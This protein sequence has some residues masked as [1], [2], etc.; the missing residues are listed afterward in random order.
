[1]VCWGSNDAGQRT[2]PGGAFLQ[3]AAGRRHTC[4]LRPDG[5]AVCWGSN[6]YEMATPPTGA[7]AQV[8]AGVWFSCGLRPNGSI[9]C[10]GRN[11][12]LQAAPPAGTFT[13]LSAGADHACA[14]R[15]DGSVACWGLNDYGQAV[16]PAGTFTQVSAGGRHTCALRPDGA[17]VCWGYNAYGQAAPP[18]GTFTQISAGSV[19]NCGIRPSGV[20]ACWGDPN[21]GKT[22]PPTG[23]FAEVSA[24]VEHACATRA[25]GT[26]VCWGA[27]TVNTG[28]GSQFGQSLPPG[29][30]LSPAPACALRPGGIVSWWPLDGSAADG[31]GKHHGTLLGGPAALSRGFV[32]AAYLFDGV[33]DRIE[34][35][36]APAL[37]PSSQM[38]LAAWVLYTGGRAGLNRDIVGK[39]ANAAGRQYLLNLAVIDRFGATVVLPGGP[40][41]GTS[42]TVPVPNRWYHLAMTY[43]GT[44]LRFYVD[45]RLEAQ[46]P[47]TGGIATGTEPLRIGGG[48]PGTLAPDYFPGVID[49]VLLF[50]RA[51]TPAEV[52]SLY[53]GGSTGLCP[54]APPSR[55]SAGGP[56]AVNEGS[57][58]TLTAAGTDPDGGAVTLAWDF[59]G[60][61]V[62]DAT[63]AS[64]S[65]TFP[66]NGAYAVS[67]TVTDDEG[68]SAKGATTVTVRNVA[69]SAGF[70][71]SPSPVG[72]NTN[73]TLTL[74]GATDPSATDRTGGLTY[75][76]DCG[77]GVFSAYGPSTSRTCPGRS[78]AGM[79]TVRGRVRDKDL[80][81][82]D[83]AKGLEISSPSPQ[84][85]AYSIACKSKGI[86]AGYLVY[87]RT[88]TSSCGYDPL[89]HTNQNYLRYFADAKIGDTRE[90]C[91]GEA[92]PVGWVRKS[93]ENQLGRCGTVATING[94]D[95][96]V[97]VR[98]Y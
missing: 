72:V 45:G 51:I 52:G 27:G 92:T 55:V 16:P 10:W 29:D 63:G 65:R 56:Y 4:A 57:P 31:A 54:L 33:D 13:Q 81:F 30:Q 61:G 70:S 12:V 82:S 22:A 38:T 48:A 83:Y 88:Y 71:V 59:T 67:V 15:P 47:A 73:Y 37:N 26:V 11:H 28:V 68:Q 60:D 39:E 24:G 7:F 91:A 53:Q 75:A 80:D 9:S 96:Y 64:V 87:D 89:G 69:P 6:D 46:T 41:K 40:V 17:A 74:T 58:L 8:R 49:D 90:I 42:T 21:F 78:V 3:V 95:Y 50:G 1:V 94:F 25:N 34:V 19:H 23:T 18:A 97:I 66:D 93:S 98:T 86:P 76:F 44:A 20:L 85:P 32:G 43:D 35:P 14:L 62:T 5:A 2:T 84:P 36:N 77:D 79:L